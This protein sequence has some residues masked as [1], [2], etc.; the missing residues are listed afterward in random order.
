MEPLLKKGK[1]GPIRDY[2]EW[3]EGEAE[4]CRKREQAR[5]AGLAESINR[6]LADIN[7]L[8][9][10][11][12]EGD[13]LTGEIRAN[14]T[15]QEN[16]VA[17]VS[18]MTEELTGSVSSITENVLG[19]ATAFIEFASVVEELTASIKS[20][21]KSAEDAKR[22]VDSLNT[23]VSSGNA[24]VRAS[25][26]AI[27]EIKGSSEKI[28]QITVVIQKIAGQSNLLAMNAAIEAAHAGQAGRGFAV[29]AE[30]MRKLSENSSLEAKKIAEITKSIFLG[31][32]TAVE[33]TSRVLDSNK[34]IVAGISQATEITNLIRDAMNE[35]SAGTDEILNETR[36]L[37]D[38]SS[39]MKTALDQQ[40]KAN[41]ELLEAVTHLR[42]SGNTFKET[43]A[44]EDRLNI[45]ILETT[46]SIRAVVNGCAAS[47]QS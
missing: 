25:M 31:I 40:S 33:T 47:L 10:L 45:S 34:E 23:T 3:L 21:A 27:N 11:Q 8:K 1:F 19:Q 14:I 38:V 16:S 13:R 20:V 12:R 35:Q 4:A 37:N 24:V 41:K 36:N 42:D 43:V 5:T 29:V 46:E 6:V 39:E 26:D 9:D 7:R 15:R 22:I 17:D 44:S 18:S 32:S 30:E 2:I 28:T